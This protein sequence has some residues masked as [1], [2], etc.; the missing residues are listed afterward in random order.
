MFHLLARRGATPTVA[1]SRRIV[2][3]GRGRAVCFSTAT[4]NTADD[5][6][7]TTPPSEYGLY[8]LLSTQERQLLVEQRNLTETSRQL[9][10][11]VGGGVENIYVQSSSFLQDLQLEASFSVVIAGEFNAGKSTLINALLG[12]K[13]L[14]S[15]ALPTTDAITIVGNTAAPETA[16][17]MPLGVILHAVSDLALLQ[18]L[19][20]VDT[21]GTNSA[22]MDHT[23]RTLRL[24][25]AADLILF[26]TSA[27]RPFSESERTLLQSIQAYRKSIVVVVNKMDILDAAGGDHGHESKQAVVDF[28][29]E[30]ARELL[31]ARP[32]VIPV[33]ARDALSAKLFGGK[34]ASDDEAQRSNVWHRSNFGALESFLKDSL[35]T[36]AKLKSKLS[37][38]IGLSEGVIAKC[39]DV[40]M[41]QRTEL[42]ADVATLNILQSQFGGWKKELSA[43]LN[44]SRQQ[45]ADMVRKEGERCAVLLNRMNFVNFHTWMLYDNHQLEQ[46]WEET[47]RQVSAHRQKELEAD[48]LEQVLETA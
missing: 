46:E 26:V 34:N 21:P 25:P 37:S 30:H 22:W 29:T 1:L 9:A 2:M 47:K 45:M 31:G 35:T 42:Q 18:D 28:V 41:E 17:N 16:E 23:E 8:R 48:L 3:R 44:Q 11:Q 14:E 39:L 13:L 10:S 32:I 40:L 43:D 27:D 19:T 36:Q 15:G 24:L 5:P 4:T 6:T 20:L 12:T 7:T 38:P 33:S